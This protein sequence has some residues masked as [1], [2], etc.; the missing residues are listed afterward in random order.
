MQR[1][2]PVLAMRNQVANIKI[3]WRDAGV[4]KKSETE[5]QHCRSGRVHR[6]H[7][8]TLVAND[9]NPGVI[10]FAVASAT[11]GVMDSTWFACVC[12]AIST[13]ACRAFSGDAFHHPQHGTLQEMLRQRDNGLGGEPKAPYV[14][15]CEQP[16]DERFQQRRRHI[17]YITA[18]DH[19]VADGRRG[20]QA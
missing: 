18:G 15:D 7:Q 3:L 9:R 1:N 8:D 5:I 6:P 17:G 4:I 16:R 12:T 11:S 14:F 10:E 2:P 13:F 20:R 19:D